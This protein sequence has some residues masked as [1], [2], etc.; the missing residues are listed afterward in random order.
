MN[1]SKNS[2]LLTEFIDWNTEY[3][4]SICGT[5][6][7]YEIIHCTEPSI[8]S[9]NALPDYFPDDINVSYDETFYQDGITIMD[10][11]SLD[12]S[13]EVKRGNKIYT[14]EIADFKQVNA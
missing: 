3:S 4:W 9:I 12:F 6:N 10:F 8:F 5:Y 2:L 11:E 14:K 13:M 7:N 1:T